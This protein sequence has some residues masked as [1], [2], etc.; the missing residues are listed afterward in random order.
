MT[1]LYNSLARTDKNCMTALSD[2]MIRIPRSSQNIKSFRLVP[3]SQ[4]V[5]V[6]VYGNS[7]Q[8]CLSV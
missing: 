8:I 2:E 3:D 1:R 4:T 6:N 5:S 7:W